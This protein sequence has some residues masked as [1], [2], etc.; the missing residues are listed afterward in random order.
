MMSNLTAELN[1]EQ[2][3]QIIFLLNFKLMTIH[4]LLT[5]IIINCRNN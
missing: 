4:Q 3:R 2:K 5:V 1:K